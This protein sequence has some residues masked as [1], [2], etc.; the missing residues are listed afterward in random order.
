[1]TGVAMDKLKIKE[2]RFMCNIGI[3]ENERNTKQEIIADIELFLDFKEVAKTDDVADTINYSDVSKFLKDFISKKEC[4]LIETLAEDIAV[5]VLKNF[6][7]E[8]ISVII[9]K[10]NALANAKYASVEITRSKNG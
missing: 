2:A 1:M 10:P 6:P 3:S 9:K 4:K 5:A 8:K 7:A